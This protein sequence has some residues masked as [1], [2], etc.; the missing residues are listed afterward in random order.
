MR[1]L[2][3]AIALG[4]AA[5]SAG[6]FA[7]PPAGP[8]GSAT[9]GSGGTGAAGGTSASTLGIG[10]ESTGPSGSGSAL[11]TG[12]SAAASQGWDKSHSFVHGGGG[13]LNG[14]AQAMGNNRGGV[15][16]KS[17]TVTHL[18]HNG[19]LSSRTKSMSHEPGGP[20]SMSTSNTTEQIPR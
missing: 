15:W 4:V 6:A 7:R 20:P 9:I 2:T 1:M 3:F 19:E 8:N 14:Q 13:N 17:H 16:S 12:G 10:G 18:N 5:G 11:G